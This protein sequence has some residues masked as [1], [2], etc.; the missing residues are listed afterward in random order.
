MDL[1]IRN[2]VALVTGGSHGIGRAIAIGLAQEG[3]NV[4]ICS[5]TEQRL[6]ATQKLLQPY[7]VQTLAIKCD[8]MNKQDIDATFKQVIDKWGTIHILINNVSGGGRWGKDIVKDTD[9]RCLD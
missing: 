8:V 3:C 9:E 2:K 1:G 6:E 7:D 4:A 5:R